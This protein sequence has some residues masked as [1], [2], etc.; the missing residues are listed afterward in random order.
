[1]GSLEILDWVPLVFNDPTN[2]ELSYKLS[3][4]PTR[5]VFL[6]GGPAEAAV[7][8]VSVQRI[9]RGEGEGEGRGDIERG[10]GRIPRPVAWTSRTQKDTERGRLEVAVCMRVPLA[11]AGNCWQ[12]PKMLACMGKCGLGLSKV[13]FNHSLFYSVF[14]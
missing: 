14:D 1:M 3:L 5:R 7:R 11:S 2:S 9:E 6:G 13:G 4:A 10:E 12:I 8:A